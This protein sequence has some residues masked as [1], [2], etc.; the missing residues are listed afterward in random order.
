[1]D[2]SEAAQLGGA[3]LGGGLAKTVLD[4]LLADRAARRSSLRPVDRERINVVRSAT[5]AMLH[6]RLVP[7]HAD[8]SPDDAFQLLP[9][10]RG[11][12]DRR[13]NRRF[14]RLSLRADAT[15]H[16]QPDFDME[17]RLDRREYG[18]LW[19]ACERVMKR[20]NRLERHR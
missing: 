6:Q 14:N 7:D 1:M 20:L 15:P 8:F 17:R 5:W 2:L 12:G 3:F 19:K 16:A 13:L 11:L 10:L 4:H 9:A 18:S